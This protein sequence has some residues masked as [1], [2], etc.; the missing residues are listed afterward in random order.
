M[1]RQEQKS[2]L[3]YKLGLLLC[4]L[5]DMVAHPD[6][7]DHVWRRQA[8]G[9]FSHD[10]PE[11]KRALTEFRD[12]EPGRV[13]QAQWDR[14]MHWLYTIQGRL[15]ECL[16]DPGTLGELLDGARK[17]MMAAIAEVPAFEGAKLLKAH[18]PFSAYCTLKDLCAS[19]TRILT[20]VDGYLDATIFY[21]Y[22]RDVSPNINVTLL[23]LPREKESR[24]AKHF[25]AFLDVSRMYAKERCPD[26]YRLVVH[27]Q[28][29]DRWLCCDGEIYEL[30][31]SAKDAGGAKPCTL[32]KLEPPEETLREIERLLKTGTELYGPTNHTHP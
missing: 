12:G 16:D 13:Y 17:D 32:A 5:E 3:I 1:D 18:S 9:K 28:V 23:T 22:L 11:F 24:K 20:W 15:D 2:E 31:C 4:L 6:K 26:T 10:I 27:N 7:H 25:E 19:A 29:H 8:S 21:R 30:G 14:V